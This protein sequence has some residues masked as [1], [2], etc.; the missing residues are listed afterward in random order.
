MV[1]ELGSP[2][3]WC[4]R[5]C[6][7]CPLTDDC[8][9]AIHNRA[10]RAA[11]RRRGVDP[12]AAETIAQ[13][14]ADD[15][16]KALE[17]LEEAAAEEEISLEGCEP[18]EDTPT[19]RLLSERGL[20]FALT[21][22]ALLRQYPE[23]GEAMLAGFLAGAKVARI[24]AAVTPSWELDPNWPLTCDTM[25]NIIL[26]ERL[27][28]VVSDAVAALEE[29]VDRQAL[30]SFERAQVDLVRALLPL[31]A[32]VDDSVREALRELTAAGG[33]PSPYCVR[34]APPMHER[35]PSRT[36]SSMS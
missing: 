1:I 30:A 29:P 18:T 32:A 13:D 17:L 3:N 6:E 12:D 22:D 35:N 11:Q 8:A 7:R 10:R 15:M 2:Y 26:I 4:D 19:Q 5:R 36:S 25:P 33:A 14:I 31:S 24:A 20:G 23:H 34:P 9:L 28:Q 27:L 16:Q 21:T